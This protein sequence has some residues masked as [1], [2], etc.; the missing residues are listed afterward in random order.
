MHSAVIAL[1]LSLTGALVILR[2]KALHSDLS[3]E[4]A[5][6]IQTAHERP[7]PRVG[8][9]AIFLSLVG[10]S[11]TSPSEE[12]HRLLMHL[13]AAGSLA[14]L[15]GLL[16]DVLQRH[17]VILR[18]IATFSS[19]LL[20]WQ[21]SGV[22]LQTVGIPVIDQ[23]LQAS[24]WFAILFSAFAVAGMANAV[25]IMDGGHGLA[26]GNAVLSLLGLAFLAFQAGDLVLAQVGLV[27][28]AAV[29]GFLVFNWPQGRLFLRDGGAH[30]LGFLIG[31]LAVLLVVRNPD[32]SPWAAL[33]ICA[34]PVV[35]TIFTI[36]RRLMSC[37]PIFKPDRLHLHSLL[38]LRWAR[39]H[40]SRL[41]LEGQN[42]MASLPALL[43]SLSMGA[44]AW[45]WPQDSLLLLVWIAVSIA[46]YTLP[47]RRLVRFR[48]G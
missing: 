48:W 30:F 21:L 10:T 38:R 14:F 47:Y 45:F 44:P 2:T 23:W 35:E 40:W 41:S 19:G 12:H 22:S 1:L 16:E 42:S 3:V 36:I 8:G 18:L 24:P 39:Q 13:L 20:A 7:T 32:I 37:H 34:Y 29:L 43:L 27:V 31:W 25:N 6:R 11:L 5:Q 9:L 17:M 46:A 28:S 33:L 4:R 26:S 15:A